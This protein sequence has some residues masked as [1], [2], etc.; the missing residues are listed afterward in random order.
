MAVVTFLMVRSRGWRAGIRS[1][2]GR[3]VVAATR[4]VRIRLAIGPICCRRLLMLIPRTRRAVHWGLGSTAVVVPP[5]VARCHSGPVALVLDHSIELDWGEE[6]PGRGRCTAEA[7]RCRAA[8][9]IDLAGR[10]EARSWDGS[11]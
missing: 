6:G 1:I 5:E 11:C 2:L 3:N 7:V 8:E 10:A 9:G 4:V